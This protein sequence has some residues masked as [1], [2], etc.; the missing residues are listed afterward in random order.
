[1]ENGAFT[2]A[3]DSASEGMRLDIFLANVL[4]LHSRSAISHL[5]KKG[6]IKVSGQISKAGYRV[7]TGDIIAGAL[8]MALPSL[9]LPEPIPL[10][11]L[12]EDDHLIVINK[13]TGLV[14]HPAPGHF[15][16]TLV[17]ALLYH[18]PNLKGIGG[19][20]RPGIV[21]RLDKDTSGV[22]VVAKDEKTHHTLSA[23]FKSRTVKKDYLALT[24]G[25][26][27]QEEGRILLP[28]GRHPTDRKKMSVH[29]TKGRP[30]ETLWRVERHF[31]G[32]SLVRATLKTGRT[33]QIRVHFAAVHHP[34]VGDPVYSSGKWLNRLLP[35]VK[36]LASTV[37]RQM[38]HAKSLGFIHPET[39]TAM[40]FE[41]EV[42]KDMAVI[43]DQLTDRQTP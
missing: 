40:S 36:R 28:V 34:I 5:I 15:T 10:E 25:Q 33:H 39:K 24:H 31:P 3:A 12:Y 2:L 19:E 26:W 43:L 13:P 22:M 32:L 21:H 11:I 6:H 1:M 23:Q 35:E 18:C 7:K 30:A 8:P 16:G 9:Y 4:P 27:H 20:I 17:N 14:V 42:P 41:T 38:L 37:Q 29:S